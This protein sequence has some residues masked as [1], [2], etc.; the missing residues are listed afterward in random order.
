[1]TDFTIG[2][3]ARCSDGDCGTV[4]RVIVDPVAK[5]VTHLVV[6]PRFGYGRLVPLELVEPGTDEVR[7]R[8]TEAQF[9]AL[10]AAEE[11]RFL[12]GA[13][14]HAGYGAEEA[15]Y[16]PYY[17]IGMGGMAIGD[18]G[19]APLADLPQT[20]TLDTVP[21]GEVGIRRGEPVEA[22]DGPIGK[23][24]G[25]VVD[26]GSHRVTHVLLQEGHLWGRKEVA[27]PIGSVTSI[28]DGIRLGMSK[29]EV[30]DLPPVELGS[31][32]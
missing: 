11:T 8:C 17:S 25:L 5:T 12:E 10:D 24:Q 28:D 4:S 6:T 16:W 9:D 13:E 19:L 2:S 14:G 29:Q 32:G 22:T 18:T 20:M 15:L 21:A 27:I 30:Q 7:L 23:V 1:M 31:H 3:E 26:P